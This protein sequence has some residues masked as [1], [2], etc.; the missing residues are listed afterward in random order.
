[1]SD[2]QGGK[3][4][5][6]FF[7]AGFTKWAGKAWTLS[8]NKVIGNSLIQAMIGGTASRITGG[9][10]ANGAFTAALQYIVNEAQRVLNERFSFTEGKNAESYL[11]ENLKDSELDASFKIKA[12]GLAFDGKTTEVS[13]SSPLPLGPEVTFTSDG[14]IEMAMRAEL[15]YDD[16][17]GVGAK[18]FIN[19]D[20]YI[21]VEASASLRWYEVSIKWSVDAVSNQYYMLRAVS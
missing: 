1:L 3:F 4:G 11:E 2:L 21:G 17:A 13:L 15:G 18:S 8:P 12:K 16:V 14:E 9:K 7:S 20:G 10:F 5:H 6:G 19:S